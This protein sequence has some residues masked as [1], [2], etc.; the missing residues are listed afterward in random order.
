MANRGLNGAVSGAIHWTHQVEA[1]VLRTGDGLRP[2][3]L[4]PGCL[5]SGNGLRPISSSGSQQ[6]N[7]VVHL[8]RSQI[9]PQQQFGATP[10][11]AIVF[12]PSE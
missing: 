5:A 6:G 10:A 7:G 8:L 11:N 1:F 3:G 4:R 12:C 9:T 2:V